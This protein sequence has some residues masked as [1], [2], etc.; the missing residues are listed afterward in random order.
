MRPREPFPVFLPVL[1]VVESD[2]VVAIADKQPSG[3]VKLYP[4]RHCNIQLPEDN[5]SPAKIATDEGNTDRKEHGQKMTICVNLCNL[6]IK[7]LSI[8]VRRRLL[9]NS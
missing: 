3:L 7:F 1:F 9:E 4:C 8:L 6:W 2:V 5:V